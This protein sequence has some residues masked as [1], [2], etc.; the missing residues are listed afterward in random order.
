MRQTLTIKL[1]PYLQEFLQCK[2]GD[3]AAEASKTTLIGAILSPLIEYAPRDYVHKPQ[4]GPEYITFELP[5]RLGNKDTKK[6]NIYISEENQREFERILSNYFKDVFFQYVDDKIRYTGE[7]KK[8]IL[9]FC[10][11]YYITFNTIT[12]EMLKKAYYRRKKQ[13]SLRNIFSVKMSLSCPLIFL[14]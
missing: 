8:C 3:E 2:L 6:G 7:I 5:D 13:A 9:G 4:K 12:Y 11:D 1:K 10:A 14:L